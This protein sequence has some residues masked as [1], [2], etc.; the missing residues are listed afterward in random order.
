MCQE[1]IKV[2]VLKGGHNVPDE[3]VIRRYSRSIKTFCI[4][5]ILQDWILYANS[6]TDFTEIAKSVNGTVEI[7]DQKI[8]NDIEQVNNL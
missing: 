2:R 7:L 3:D 8:Y 1:R 4:Q 5:N 6:T